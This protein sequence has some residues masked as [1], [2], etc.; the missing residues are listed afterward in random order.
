M[1]IIKRIRFCKAVIENNGICRCVDNYC[2]VFNFKTNGA[3]CSQG[4]ARYGAK[5]Y[6]KNLKSKLE[7]WNDLCVLK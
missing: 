6:L 1:N 4:T 3:K 7:S 2:P 5:Q